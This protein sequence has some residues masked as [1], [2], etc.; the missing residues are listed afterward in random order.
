M[1]P[2]NLPVGF[3]E[4]FNRRFARPALNAHRP[5]RD[6][7]Q[8]PDIFTWREKRMA[9]KS[10]TLYYKRVMYILEGHRRDA[11]RDGQP[12]RHHRD[13]KWRS[14]HLP[15]GGVAAGPCRREGRPCAAGRDR[16]Q[17]GARRGTAA[18]QGSFSSSAMRRSCGR[19]APPSVTNACCGLAKKQRRHLPEQSP[20]GHFYLTLE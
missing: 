13:E 3:M 6:D 10:L 1:R 4:D 15:Q 8:L 12:G 18:C 2:T 5:L 9:S 7:E 16:R 14:A 19:P 11:P 20:S 17:Q